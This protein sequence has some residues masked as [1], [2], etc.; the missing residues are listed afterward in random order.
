MQIDA[1]I[2]NLKSLEIDA[3]MTIRVHIHKINLIKWP[4]YVYSLC[5]PKCSIYDPIHYIACVLFVK[6]TN[7][8]LEWN[9]HAQNSK[10][11]K[12]TKRIL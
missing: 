9:H 2:K 7:I 1:C 5:L 4:L 3:H 11:T 6:A 12:K 8:T 10:D